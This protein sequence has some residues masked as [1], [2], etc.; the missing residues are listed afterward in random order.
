MEKSVLSKKL[1]KKALPIIFYGFL[2]KLVQRFFFKKSSRDFLR[3]P[4]IALQNLSQ[5]FSNFHQSLEIQ[6]GI[7]SKISLEEFIKEIFFLEIRH[8]F[9][10]NRFIPLKHAPGYPLRKYSIFFFQKFLRDSFE[11]IFYGF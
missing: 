8:N 7:P 9:F 6:H 4:A 5:I 10:P 3:Y 2:H 1:V 11:N